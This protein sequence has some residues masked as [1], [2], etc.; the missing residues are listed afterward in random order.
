MAF[1]PVA[2]LVQAVMHLAAAALAE[3]PPARPV[4]AEEAAWAAV[5][6][7]AVAVAASAV[8]GDAVVVVVD[9]VVVAVVVVNNQSTR[10][11]K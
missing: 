7:V 11:N 2:D 3:A 5:D 8:E 9:A 6:L 1:H 10:K 4:L